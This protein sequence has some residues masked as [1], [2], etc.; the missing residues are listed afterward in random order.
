[1]DFTL[2][3]T[4]QAV[5]GVAGQVLRREVDRDPGERAWVGEPGYHEAAWKAL[6]HAGLLS[7]ALPEWLGGEA[8]GVMDTAVVLAEV[9][10]EVAPVPALATLALGVLPVV[11]LGTREQQEALLPAVAAGGRVLT[12]ALHEPSTPMPDV[13]RTT[14]LRTAEGLVVSGTKVGVPHAGTAHRIL[15]PVTLYDGDTAVLLVNPRAPGVSLLRT[16]TSAGAPEYTLRLDDVRVPADDQLGAGLAGRPVAELHRLAVAGACAL[17]DGVLAG[18]LALTT[19]H[20]GSRKQFGR[21]LATFQAVAQQIADVYVAAR[22]LHLVA[23]SACWRLGTDRDADTDLDV[24]AHWLAEELPA[25]LHVCHHL[26]GGLGV[27]D[28]YPL[29]RYYSWAK[30]LARF[31]GGRDHRLDRLGERVGN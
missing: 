17:G 14:A 7:L 27:D 16:P 15:V 20:I 10:R 25:A 30:D 31:V 1:V 18:A 26:H 22:T 21:P 23:W 19:A 28:T 5:A 9:G 29:H 3:E 24:A 4:Q 2:E 6:G 12:A 8:L 13:P 11:R